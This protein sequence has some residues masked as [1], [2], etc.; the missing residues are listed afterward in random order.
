MTPQ[1]KNND[2]NILP[3]IPGSRYEN[4]FNVYTV[5]KNG[6]NFYFYNIN[7][8]L[9]LPT[10]IDSLFINTYT[11]EAE[12]PWTILSYKLYGN[13]FLWYILYTMNNT[14]SKPMFTVPAGTTISYIK[15]EFIN[16]IVTKINE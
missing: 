5:V 10:E 6:K 16:N 11:T 4:I 15:S 2:I 8:K 13:M 3:P 14:R 7:T 1:V 12:L 9:I